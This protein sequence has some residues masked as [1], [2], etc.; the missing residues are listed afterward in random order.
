[1]SWLE[2]VERRTVDIIGYIRSAESNQQSVTQYVV[3]DKREARRSKMAHGKSSAN[4]GTRAV[5][6]S[7]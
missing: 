6:R 7:F 5:H 3:N 1:M 4:R 2:Q